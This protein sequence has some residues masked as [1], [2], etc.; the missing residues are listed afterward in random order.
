MKQLKD[1][2]QK[3]G[4]CNNC[5]TKGRLIKF[6]ECN[7]SPCGK[8]A[9]EFNQNVYKPTLLCEKCKN[10]CSICKKIFCPRHLNSSGG[11]NYCDKCK[12]K[13]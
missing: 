10:N 3:Q 2:Y 4:F 6:E 7:Y 1:A 5:G 9:I 11:R 8:Y 12:G 13:M